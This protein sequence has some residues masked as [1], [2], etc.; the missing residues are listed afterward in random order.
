MGVGR[1]KEDGVAVLF[2]IKMGMDGKVAVGRLGSWVGICTMVGEGVMDGVNEAVG[3]SSGVR[4][5]VAL[6]TG[7]AAGWLAHAEDRTAKAVKRK[8]LLKRDLVEVITP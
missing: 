8:S 5:T 1:V 3:V 4:L 7:V 6:G 2:P